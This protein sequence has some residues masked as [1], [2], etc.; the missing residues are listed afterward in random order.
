M[1]QKDKYKLYLLTAV[2]DIG[3]IYVLIKKNIPYIDKYWLYTSLFSHAIFFYALKYHNR[4]ILDY[5]H[6]MV[7]I[8]IATSLMTKTIYVKNLCL[9][10]LI[11]MQFLWIIEGRCILNEKDHSLDYNGISGYFA[12]ILTVAL[13]FQI[14]KSLCN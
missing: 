7:F 11:I 12:I 8:L 14:G 4:K 1:E 2:L 6:Y 3:F 13:S 5:L 10:L 9:F